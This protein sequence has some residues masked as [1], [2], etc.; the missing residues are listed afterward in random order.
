MALDFASRNCRV[1]IA[2][3]ANSEKTVQKLKEKTHNPNILYK[4]VDLTNFDSVRAFAKDIN[5]TEERVDI[6]MNNAGSWGFGEDVTKEGVPLTMQLNHFG[7]FLLTHLLVDKLKQSAPSRVVFTSSFLSYTNKLQVGGLTSI[8][9]Y[10]EVIMTEMFLYGNSKLCNMMSADGFAKRLEG[11]GV[12][13]NS[14]HPGWCATRIWERTPKEK[15]FLRVF[16]WVTEKLYM[17]VG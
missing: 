7:P 14:F 17:K 3:I 8:P 10:K 11:T 5:A 15:Y 12:T 4:H 13:V 2:D 16:N 6:L 1:I 9:K